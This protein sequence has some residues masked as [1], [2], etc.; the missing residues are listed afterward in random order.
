MLSGHKSMNFYPEGG[1]VQAL[2]YLIWRN[3]CSIFISRKKSVTKRN[4]V[5]LYKKAVKF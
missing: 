3:S 2:F 4:L 5:S 1:F